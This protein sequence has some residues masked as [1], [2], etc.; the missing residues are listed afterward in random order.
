MGITIKSTRNGQA[1]FIDGIE[2][3]LS[4]PLSP[5]NGKE[6][7]IFRFAVWNENKKRFIGEPVDFTVYAQ[8]RGVEFNKTR[9]GPAEKDYL[10]AFRNVYFEAW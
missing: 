5:P 1:V 3:D 4:L 7:V 9:Y 6:Q 2:R 8:G 10:F